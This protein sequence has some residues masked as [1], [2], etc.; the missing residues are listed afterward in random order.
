MF[1]ADLL[2]QRGLFL[3]QR[4]ELLNALLL[5][6]Q[7]AFER[8][9]PW[10][11]RQRGAGRSERGSGEQGEAHDSTHQ[12]AR[13]R[14]LRRLSHSKV[15]AT[16]MVISHRPIATERMRPTRPPASLDLSPLAHRSAIR[17]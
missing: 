16:I 2:E 1:G 12:A 11:L 15:P 4:L 5:L 3:N 8:V 9:E 13:A 6:R 7:L 10:I 17:K 14:G